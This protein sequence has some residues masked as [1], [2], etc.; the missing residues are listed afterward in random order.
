MKEKGSIPD[1]IVQVINRATTFISSMHAD[2]KADE[3]N[4]ETEYNSESENEDDNDSEPT[5]GALFHQ[6]YHHMN[7]DTGC[8]DPYW[9]LLENKRTVDIFSNRALLENLKDVDDP[10]DIYLSGG[11]THCSTAG[12]LKNIGEVYLHEN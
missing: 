8:L 10:I 2:H 5:P 6:V 1:N 11:A 3:S 9:I 12:T 7:N 4:G